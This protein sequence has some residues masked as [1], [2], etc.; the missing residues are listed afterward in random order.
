MGTNGFNAMTKAIY[1]EEKAKWDKQFV[2][3]QDT[4]AMMNQVI[5]KIW[6]QLSYEVGR[7]IKRSFAKTN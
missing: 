3:T 4:T 6:P 2:C 1:N 7:T 5:S